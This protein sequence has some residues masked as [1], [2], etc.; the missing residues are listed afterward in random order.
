MTGPSGRTS[1][2]WTRAAILDHLPAS[3]AVIG[4]DRAIQF[5]NRAWRDFGLAN[6]RDES[7]DDV[8]RSYVEWADTDGDALAAAAGVEDVIDGTSAL[9][10]FAYACHGPEVER[11]FQCI[12]V[13]LDRRTPRP[14][15]SI[16]MPVGADTADRLRRAAGATSH[17]LA[18]LVMVCAW[19]TAKELSVTG[20]WVA[21]DP[22]LH[23]PSSLS[24][25]ICPECATGF[26]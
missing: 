18:G 13:P 11:W 22:L 9:F 26:R 2:P 6:G 16:H 15:L 24:H 1:S 3:A 7:A 4:P 20:D 23:P 25:G 12:V 8:G 5:V 17:R 21:H 10:T 19:C 14:V